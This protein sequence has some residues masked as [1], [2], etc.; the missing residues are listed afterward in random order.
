MIDW[1]RNGMPEHR[2]SNQPGASE[3]QRPVSGASARLPFEVE[4]LASLV[5]TAGDYLGDLAVRIR[6]HRSS[7]ITR[8]LE[9]FAREKPVFFLSGAFLVGVG[10]GRLLKGAPSPQLTTRHVS[11]SQPE[12][13]THA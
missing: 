4:W 1:G 11:S 3:M 6:D 5:Q 9:R 13:R 7:D 12:G 10:V 8:E 2:D